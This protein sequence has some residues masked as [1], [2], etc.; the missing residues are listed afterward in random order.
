MRKIKYYTENEIL[1]NVLCIIRFIKIMKG[2]GKADNFS[3]GQVHS[4]FSETEK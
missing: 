2:I 1:M 3:C 4:E